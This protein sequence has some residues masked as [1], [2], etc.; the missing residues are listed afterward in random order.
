MVPVTIYGF[1]GLKERIESQKAVLRSLIDNDMIQQ[2]VSSSHT[3]IT[4]CDR[5]LRECDE[6]QSRLEEQLIRV[7]GKIESTSTKSQVIVTNEE[8]MQKLVKLQREV[9]QATYP[10][11][12]FFIDWLMLTRRTGLRARL[13]TVYSALNTYGLPTQEESSKIE[14][15]DSMLNVAKGRLC[16]G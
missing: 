6:K 14:N 4:E 9:S 15:F 16:D 8:F 1:N 5:L 10:F 2:V 13:S 3:M 11:E 12:R 7:L